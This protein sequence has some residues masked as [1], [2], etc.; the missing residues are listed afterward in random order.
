MS[1]D[2]V[3]PYPSVRIYKA[4]D[5]LSDQ[6][7]NDKDHLMKITKLGLKDF[8]ELAELCLSKYYF[9]WNNEIRILKNLLDYLL[10]LFYLK[11]TFRV[12]NTKPL[13]KH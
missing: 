8:Y 6:L 3:N 2:I 13:Q 11:V 1:Y 10:W 9:F 4:I 7:N 12:W 5:F